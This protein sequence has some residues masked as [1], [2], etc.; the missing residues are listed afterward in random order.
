MKKLVRKF[1]HQ[2]KTKKG[3]EKKQKKKGKNPNEIN[4]KGKEPERDESK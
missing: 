1:E 2:P 4:P 3:G